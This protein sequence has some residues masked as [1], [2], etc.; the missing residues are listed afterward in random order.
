[1]TK[2]LRKDRA[3][4][5]VELF[6]RQVA[7]SPQ[8]RA[9]IFGN[10]CLSY[11]E[12]NQ[13]AN[14]LAHYLNE[15]DLKENCPIAI[16]MDRSIELLI[17]ILGILKAGGA[18]V[19]LDPSY[20]EE[21]LLLILNEGRIPILITTSEKATQF[22]RYQGRV[23]FNDDKRLDEQ[24]NTN[25]RAIVN[26]H[27][28]AYIIYTSGSSGKP[29]GVLIEHRSITNYAKWLAHYSGLKPQDSI[30]FSSNHAF[31]FAL[32]TS[33]IPLMLGLRIVICEDKVKKDP[34]LYFDYL[35]ANKI[36]CIKITPGYFNV[37]LYQAKVKNF[38]LNYLKKIIL[39]G[40]NLLVPDCVSWLALFPNHLLFNEYGPTEATVAVCVNRIDRKSI[41]NLSSNVPIGKLMP[42]CKAYILDE[43]GKPIIDDKIGELYLG[44]I[45]LAKGYLNDKK[46]TDQSFIQDPFSSPTNNARL[47]KTGDLCRRLS[48]GELECIGRIDNQVKIRGFR[49]EPAEIENLLTLHPALK[50]AVVNPI[51]GCHK[52]KI[53][54]AYYI[55]KNQAKTVTEKELR[56]YLKRYLPDFMI[57]SAF[58]VMDSFPLNANEKIDR[59]ALAIPSL[60]PNSKHE[61]AANPLEKTLAE[62]W[63]NELG[64]RPIGVTDNFFELGGHS[65]SAARIISTITQV[66]RKELSMQNFYQNPTIKA[67]C[68]LLGKQEKINQQIEFPEKIYKDNLQLPLSDFQFSLWLSTIFEPKAKKLAICGR[69]RFQGHLDEEKFAAAFNLVLK[70]HEVL[71]YQVSTF[72]PTQYSEKNLDLKIEIT[73]LESLT[74]EASE[75]LLETSLGELIAYPWPKNCTPLI[76][77][78]FY[79]TEG[80]TELQLC[81]PH[82]LSDD[83]SLEILFSDLSKFYLANEPQ[84]LKPDKTYREYLFTEQAYIQDHLDHDLIF[85]EQYLQDGALFAFPAEYVV[86]NMKKSK[87][88]YSRYTEISKKALAKLRDYC[89]NNHISLDNGLSGVLLL[90]LYNCCGQLNISSP[91]CINKVKST[92]DNSKYDNSI[93]CFLTIEP[94]KLKLNS[95]Q[96][97][98]S[99]CQQIHASLIA[100]SPY[101][102]CSNLVK[103]ASISNFRKT[104]RTRIFLINSLLSIYNFLLPSH[105]LNKKIVNCGARIKTPKTNNFLININI[106]NSFLKT[107]NENPSLFGFASESTRTG[108]YDLLTIDNLLDVCFLRMADQKPYMVISAN[109]TLDFHALLSKEV[110]KLCE[111]IQ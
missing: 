70:K 28:L 45:C 33:I 19:P 12:L 50:S 49:I 8:A 3:N 21:R 23:L 13:K 90:A 62:I 43:T 78:L 42:N 57:P 41:A 79:L 38:S 109:L 81:L 97:L 89:L 6:E 110:I 36:H 56:Q 77:R 66:L 83:I 30:D 58:I 11:E 107:E 55:L 104:S 5:L 101:Q 96:G 51:V 59:K 95:Q 108:Q 10:D 80:K 22:K 18:Y 47:Y 4:T 100:T 98:N 88:P 69:K 40:E 68:R 29:K 44:G 85:W 53:L 34:K 31:D 72:K 111:S 99:L 86:A 1:M 20:P 94:I 91:I 106:H 27:Q 87:I 74:Q 61:A 25:P 24:K 82:I 2:K 75:V 84:S 32:T 37:L 7:Q 93:G 102:K 67:L 60:I 17:V 103:L 46:L 65:L 63:S 105:K 15:L 71:S 48:K 39:G 52:E 92:R 54:I 73:N 35:A 64:L 26:P 76:A 9:V 16:F 14:Q